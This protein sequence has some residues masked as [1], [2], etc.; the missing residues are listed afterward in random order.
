MEKW[1]MK[2]VELILKL[3]LLSKKNP[4]VI[5]YAPQK[6]EVSRHEQPTLHRAKPEK[7]GVP[8]QVLH[9]MLEELENEPKSRLH[10][11]FVVKDGGL[12]L[13]NIF[14]FWENL[15]I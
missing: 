8:N 6:C 2:S 1:T 11:L 13:V 10:T 7:R 15:F 3:S 14:C 4:A 9:K 5:P 12:V